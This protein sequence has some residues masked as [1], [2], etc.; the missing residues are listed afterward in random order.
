VASLRKY[1][2]AGVARRYGTEKK[3][4]LQKADGLFHEPHRA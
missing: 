2:F 4:D 3:E 1:R